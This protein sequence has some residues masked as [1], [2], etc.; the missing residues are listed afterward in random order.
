MRAGQ[1]LGLRHGDFV[2]RS[3]EIRIVARP[4]NANGARAKLREAAVIPVSTPLV[5]LYP[6]DMHGEYGDLDCDYVFVNLFGGRIGQ[7]LCYPAVHRLAARIS[8][9]TGIAFTVHMLRHTHATELK[10]S[11][12]ASAASFGRSGKRALPAV[13]RAALEQ[14]RSN[15]SPC[16]PRG[17]GMPSSA[18]TKPDDDAASSVASDARMMQQI[19]PKNAATRAGDTI[20]CSSSWPIRRIGTMLSS[21]FRRGVPIEVVAGCSRTGPRRPPARPTSISMPPTC[22]RPPQQDCPHPNACL[23]CPDF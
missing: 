3:R 15:G 8:A 6:E 16:T 4:D 14:A 11:G 12:V 1:A 13:Q 9:R 2:S 21:S 10:V 20:V 18:C 7:P 19:P 23:T 5:R 17:P 22:E